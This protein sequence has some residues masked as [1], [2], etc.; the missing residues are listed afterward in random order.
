[1]CN[2]QKSFSLDGFEPFL[3]RIG[4]TIFQM[5]HGIGHTAGFLM[6]F[7]KSHKEMFLFFKRNANKLMK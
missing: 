6:V 7:V 3:H 5:S 4:D 1:M 2:E